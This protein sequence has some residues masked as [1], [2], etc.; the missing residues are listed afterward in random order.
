MSNALA[1][2][3][4]TATIQ[5]W[6]NNTLNDPS[7]PLGSVTVT[8]KAPDIA[9]GH[10]NP[11]QGAD[12]LV[13]LFL[14][15]VTPNAAWRNI[16]LPTLGRDGTSK[17]TNQPLAL[18]LHYLLTAYATQDTEAEALL[19]YAVLMLHETPVLARGQIITALGALP[20]TNPYRTVLASSGIADQIEMIK[21]TPATLGREE[22]A[23]LWTALKADYR[24][25]FPFQVSVVLIEPQAPTVSPLPVMKRVLAAQ[26]S[27]QPHLI[28]ILPPPNQAAPGPGDIA[29]ANGQ[30]LTGITKIALVNGRL[31]INYPT[32]T[33]ATTS[34]GT[35][36]FVV[37]ND[38]PNLPAGIY[39]VSAQVTDV[40]N[41]IL[42]SSNSVMMAIAP[43]ILLAPAPSAVNNASGTLVTIHCAPQARPSQKVELILG[44]T[45]AP[46]VPFSVKTSQ[47]TFQFPHLVP[48]NYVGRLSVDGIVSAVQV[49]WAANPPFFIATVVIP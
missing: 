1:L 29:T 45:S 36:T 27:L 33:P 6:L 20:N 47:L 2:S 34:P 40:A 49:N 48:G 13:N 43:S 7:S 21:I 19:G 18:D 3:A 15:Q 9:Q 26:A 8:A 37:P 30:Y 16:G 44:S 46:A 38:P 22:M 32:F 11:G 41:N 24:P 5:Y 14:H 17:L 28:E 23:W 10:I 4:V 35:L 39:E 25:T 31:G 12:L 42:A